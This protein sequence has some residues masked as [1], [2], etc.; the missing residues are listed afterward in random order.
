MIR[1]RF[2]PSPTGY[3]HIGSLRTALYAYLF[4]KKNKGTFILRIE[5]TDQKRFVPG[6]TENLIKVLSMFG[7]DYDE[8]PTLDG[9]EIG[10]TGPYIQSKRSELYM[11]HALELVEKG[12]AYYCFCTPERLDE[13]RKTQSSAGL[14]PMYDRH[15][16]NLSPEEV[17]QKIENGE[18][19][20][21]RQKIPNK[22]IGYTDMIRGRIDFK[23]ITLDDQVLIK[24]DGLP[25]YHLANVVDDH[26][27]KISHVIRAEE[28][29]PSTP[30][31]IFLYESFGWTPP[32][33]A[34]L[35][36]VLNKDRTKL[37]K[38]QGDVA[39]EDYLKK[40]Y[41][42]EALINFVAM[43]GWN[44]GKGSTEEIFSLKELEELFTL[45]TV[46]KAGA[47]FDLDKLKWLN[48][49]WK[50]RLFDE[51]M[52]SL[53]VEIDDQAQITLDNKKNLKIAF[54]LPEKAE[55]F[56]RKKGEK[57]LSLSSEYIPETMLEN[58]DLL[59]KALCV[60]EDKVHKNVME[61]AKDIEFFFTLPDYS[62]DLFVNEK[63]GTTKE[64][65]KTVLEK[66]KELLESMNL[67]TEETLSITI[68][69]TIKE[70]NLKNGQ[71]LW[72]IRVALSGLP[73]SPGVFESLWVLGKEESLK[74]IDTAIEKL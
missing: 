46:H 51:E 10:D 16:A 40:G 12:E 26:Y 7:I 41:C 37:S 23:S 49:N 67:W 68:I 59:Y 5:D 42:I 17:K 18:K 58:R 33:Y 4:A 32:E 27:M 69:D 34:H 9:S 64:N 19:W 74:R 29:I 62:A 43:L 55:E 22:D 21:I 66:A 73:F 53:V 2:A 56:K 50:K 60:C 70:L 57:L 35:P 24:S 25:T 13:L 71:F 8:G 45:E 44:P 47:I 36:L 31:H 63:M 38:R 48:Y 20:V 6:A 11:K 14:P 54:S 1:T 39:V 3:V 28:W 61:I 65:S 52:R 15:C 72:P 30:K